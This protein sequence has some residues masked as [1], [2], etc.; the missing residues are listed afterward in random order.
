MFLKAILS[1]RT[2]LR[3]RPAKFQRARKRW[4]KRG[5]AILGA[6]LVCGLV[7]SC[8][9]TASESAQKP[10]AEM[11]V[12]R[13]GVPGKQ[14]FW[15]NNSGRFIYPPAFDFKQVEKAVQ[16]RFCTTAG[17]RQYVFTSAHPW[18]ALTPV[19]A[20]LPEG[21][22]ELTVEGLDSQGTVV[23]ISGRRQFYRSPGF[24]GESSSPVISHS[25]AGRL[26]LR[27]LFVA[28]HVQ[29]WLKPGGQ[30]PDYTFYC[31]PA[32]MVGALMRTMA[33]FAKC[34]ATGSERKD[35][36]LIGQRAADYLIQISLPK[37]ARYEFFP[38]TY[39]EEVHHPTRAARQDFKKGWMMT[40]YGCDAAFGYLDLYALTR[41]DKYLGAA[42]R[43]ADTYARTQESDGTWP[44]V[45][46]V[47][48]G[49]AET[50]NRMVPAWVIFLFDRLEREY[51]ISSYRESRQRA[52][53]YIETNP[54]R[55]FAWDAQFEDAQPR[56]PYRNLS[57]EQACDVA[58]I[59]L[60]EPGKDPVRLETAKELLR[61]GEDQFIVWSPVK[62]PTGW[63]KAG[64]ERQRKPENWLTPAVL[65]Q[66]TWYVPIARSSAVFIQAYMAAFK[67]TGEAVYL[68][69]ARAL[70]NTLVAGQ[71]YQQAHHGGNGEIPT[72]LA[73]EPPHNWLNISFYSAQALIELG[74]V[75]QEQTAHH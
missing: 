52:W 57:R 32:K 9:S 17:D 4:Q 56:P 41:E 8:K 42:R 53:K 11:N 63:R 10:G 19:W 68:Q 3:A 30:D 18:D 26:G 34:E 43:I 37:G 62:D 21:L 16:Y 35:A 7:N 44:L 55:T 71:Q 73:K 59:L 27:S 50:P 60:E 46:N 67:A 61:F 20:Q 69:K 58:T 23:G 5:A 28:D 70:A 64:L 72:W 48:T 45:V 39:S 51:G 33:A 38:P 40:H 75:E 12:I 31:Y 15:N 25:A 6:L 2:A 13:P 49:K 1:C 54:L 24:N 66:Y 74:Q 65:E 29:H 14:P 36:L 47:E 22:T